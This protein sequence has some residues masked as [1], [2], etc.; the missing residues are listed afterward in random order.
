MPPI[1][2]QPQKKP[3]LNSVNGLT[4]HFKDKNV[5]EISFIGFGVPLNIYKNIKNSIISINK[6]RRKSRRF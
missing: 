5:S 4:Y 3:N 2:E 6:H 1:R